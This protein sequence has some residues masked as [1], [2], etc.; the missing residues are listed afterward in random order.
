MDPITSRDDP[1]LDSIAMALHSVCL[2]L[3]HLVVKDGEGA[4]KFVTIQVDGAI[5]YVSARII[6]C[7]IANSPLIKTAMAAGDA[8]W[9]RI[10]MAIGKS[11]EPINPDALAIW[12]DD[13]QVAKDGARMPD[14]SEEAASAVFA[15]PEFTVR[16]DVGAG[17]DSAT[18][19]TCDLTHA[20]IDINGAYRT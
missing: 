7:E 11:L 15:Q 14:Y 6:A 5:S 10:V 13:V 17:E 4:Q 2:E 18:V 1:R 12:F 19:W 3:A 16:V 20:Y 9:G 8:N